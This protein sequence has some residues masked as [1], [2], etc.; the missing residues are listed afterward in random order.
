M[1]SAAASSTLI[2][3][4]LRLPRPGIHLVQ[5]PLAG[6][7][8]ESP[9]MVLAT[10]K[11]TSIRPSLFSRAL[12]SSNARP[13]IVAARPQAPVLSLAGPPTQMSQT[14]SLSCTLDL[15]KLLSLLA[16]KTF[17]R[18]NTNEW[19]FIE[20]LPLVDEHCLVLSRLPLYVRS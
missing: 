9:V 2:Q 16:R 15:P 12:T 7:A 20:K 18:L 10:T 13:Q 8:S 5:L 3:P 19:V 1:A 4:R 17:Q 6:R 14:H 11:T